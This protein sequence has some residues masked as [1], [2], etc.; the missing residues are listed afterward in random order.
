M[1][2]LI[3]R[4]LLVLNGGWNCDILFRPDWLK[5]HL[6]PDCEDMQLNI[7]VAANRLP[8]AKLTTPMAT[9]DIA[10]NR[11][12]FAAN[13]ESEETEGHV[14][15]VATRLVEILLHT[16]FSALGVNFV[17]QVP[18]G[19]GL[20]L[21]NL[22]LL[23]ALGVNQDPL[24]QESIQ[25]TS[26]VEGT[27][28]GDLKPVRL[29]TNCKISVNGEGARELEFA[30]NFHRP[31]STPGDF[32]GGLNNLPVDECRKRSESLAQAVAKLVGE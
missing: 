8:V 4:P 21:G 16:S 28:D 12:A 6:F 9:L 1:K 32:K 3:E 17:Y 20:S 13:Q 24:R 31:I 22:D 10:P 26:I 25:L 27:D 19:T 15:D 5:R 30:T 18:V 11:V 2:R 29:T 14:C 7:M 23:R